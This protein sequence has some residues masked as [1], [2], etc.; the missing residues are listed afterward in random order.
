M[1]TR[2][3]LL[4]LRTWLAAL[5]VIFST[6]DPGA[7]VKYGPYLAVA[8]WLTG[9]PAR[10]RVSSTIW[11]TIAFGGWIALSSK[12]AINPLAHQDVLIWIS[13]LVMFLGVQ[14]LI[15]STRQ[16]R[17]LAWS[18]LV[19]LLITV[20]VTV[21][22]NW[23]AISSA[24]VGRYSADQLNANY[25]GYSLAAGFAMIVLLWETKENSFTA[26]LGL[27]GV[28]AAIIVGIELTGTR[29]AELGVVCLL[30]WLLLCRTFRTPPIRLL[31]VTLTAIAIGITTGLLDPVMGLLDFGSRGGGGLSGRLSLWPIARELWNSSPW[32][33]NGMWAMRASNPWGVDAHSVFLEIGS[34]LG[35]IGVGLFVALLWS[36][37]VTGTR[38]VEKRVRFLVIGSLLAVSAP[39][40]FSGAWEATPTA[41]M[42]LAIF[43]RISVLAAS[44]SSGGIVVPT[45]DAFVSPRA[46]VSKPHAGVA[47]FAITPASEIPAVS[48]Y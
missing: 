17:F 3:K 37:L 20:I 22:S 46:K 29:G 9:N 47:R 6:M 45:L 34:A 14:D 32:V 19:G 48:N 25:V 1:H 11:L 31:T 30:A 40:Y 23:S 10:F 36:I 8:L 7:L 2:S 24:G 21:V 12:W 28:G 39:A 41:W 26:K 42:I 43:S 44:D 5:M 38:S 16:L 4:G 15:K 18:Y 13:L 33:G 27:V 35:I